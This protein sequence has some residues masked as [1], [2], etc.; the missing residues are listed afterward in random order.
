VKSEPLKEKIKECWISFSDLTSARRRFWFHKTK[1]IYKEDVKSAVQWLLKEIEK[2]KK[3]LGV[4]N[5][6]R[7]QQSWAWLEWFE[8]KIKKAFEGVIE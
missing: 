7:K 8:Q 5:N 2:E 4:L 6:E 3:E 1:I